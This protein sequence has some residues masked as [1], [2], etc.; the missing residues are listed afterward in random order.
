MTTEERIDAVR[1]F[2]YAKREA[3]FLVHAALHSGYFLSRQFTRWIG[4]SPGKALTEFAARAV[5]LQHIS[6]V[7]G[8]RGAHLYHVSAKPLFAVLDQTDNRHRRPR[9][10]L[11]IKAKVMAL[12]YVLDH[13]D[14]PFLATEAER[15]EYFQRVWGIERAC[16]PQRRYTS[17][18]TQAVTVRYFVDKYPIATLAQADA[19]P[20]P[21]LTSPRSG[22]TVSF[23]FIDEGAATVG[24]FSTYLEQYQALL[25]RL[26]AWRVVYAA[27]TRR[28]FTQAAA[29]FRRARSGRAGTPLSASG[30]AALID[31]FQLRRL[32]EAREFTHLSKAKLDRLREAR[33]VFQGDRIDRVYAEWL[34]VGDGAVQP[35]SADIVAIGTDQ[36]FETYRLDHA[37]DLW[38]ETGHQGAVPA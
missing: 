1:A 17:R 21:G 5:A 8:R 29:A 13:V 14:Q 38:L 27:E 24:A 18:R 2:G 32:Y 10:A 20:A 22:T 37:Y 3:A 11:E 35:P 4:S 15:V 26:P 16:L 23:I 31:Y 25:D 9:P 19:A 30:T 6:I 33:R 36:R 7:R 28:R 12:D 34:S